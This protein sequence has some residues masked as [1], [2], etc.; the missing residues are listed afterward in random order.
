MKKELIVGIILLLA[1]AVLI[2][3]GQIAENDREKREFGR[4][5]D[6]DKLILLNEKNLYPD[7]LNVSAGDSVMWV[8]N[9]SD[10]I[11]GLARIKGVKGFDLDSGDLLPGEIFEYRFNEPGTYEF[12]DIIRF[13]PGRVVV[14]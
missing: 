2:Y 13:F 5:I 7:E 14:R 4:E 12:I 9:R 1:I 3:T 8:N 11:S 10:G 6:L